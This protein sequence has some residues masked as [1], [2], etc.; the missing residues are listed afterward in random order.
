MDDTIPG[1][2][3]RNKNLIEKRLV[4]IPEVDIITRFRDGVG[5]VDRLAGKEDITNNTAGLVD[6]GVQFGR[7]VGG[8][9][10]DGVEG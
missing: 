2:T 7:F 8:E 10:G 5:V 6:V 9:V 4:L 3:Q 1:R